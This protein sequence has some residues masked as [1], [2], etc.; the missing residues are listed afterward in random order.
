MNRKVHYLRAQFIVELYTFY[1]WI[2]SI[3][4]VF[5]RITLQVQYLVPAITMDLILTAYFTH[6]YLKAPSSNDGDSL[7]RNSFSS[8][9]RAQNEQS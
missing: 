2:S 4:D 6:G 8:C 7:S 5:Y 1:H 9:G 3:F